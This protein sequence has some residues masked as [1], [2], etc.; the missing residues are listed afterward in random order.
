MIKAVFKEV[1]IGIGL[2]LIIVLVMGIVFYGYF[3][4]SKAT[5]QVSK[6]ER[7]ESLQ[8]ELSLSTEIDN[9]KTIIT[10]DIG[11]RELN[12]YRMTDKLKQ[13]KANPFAISAAGSTSTGSGSDNSSGNNSSDNTNNNN[14]SNSNNNGESYSKDPNA[15]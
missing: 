11:Q 13:G 12:G 1:L 15:K 9:T 7:P 6:Y 4:T 10:Y 3:P 5:P 14:T 8:E 2:C